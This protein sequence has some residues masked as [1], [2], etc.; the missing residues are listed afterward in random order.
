MSW[1]AG[2][3]ALA[4]LGLS[5]ASV[6]TL[7]PGA[8]VQLATDQALVFGR[9]RVFAGARELTPWKPDLLEEVVFPEP[10]VRLALFRVESEERAFAPAP[11]PDGWFAWVL[12]A[13]T[14]LVY[15]TEQDGRVR[16]DVLAA[17]QV[18]AANEAQYAGEF[19]LH[20]AVESEGDALAYRVEDVA[21][22]TDPEAARAVLARRNPG[23]VLALADHA[24]GSSGELRS[25]FDD[26]RRARA[27]E[28][29]A[30]LGLLVAPER[31]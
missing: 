26:W 1:L 30:G 31:R 24:L 20:G 12:S 19:E 25:L 21:V 8:G 22:H 3:V 9:V 13:G 2:L 14:W 11:D 15:H 5:C 7:E 27:L 28:V 16:H 23:A 18:R 29:L 4:F 10:D 6:R 17:F